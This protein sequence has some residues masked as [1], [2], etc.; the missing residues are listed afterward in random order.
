MM[1]S[2]W[3]GD[4][5]DLLLNSCSIGGGKSMVEA[6]PFFHVAAL[7]LIYSQEW[8]FEIKKEHVEGDFIWFLVCS[9]RISRPNVCPKIWESC[10]G[11]PFFSGQTLRCEVRSWC[12]SSLW[13]EMLKFLFL[14]MHVCHQS[15]NEVNRTTAQGVPQDWRHA[16]R[17][18]KDL[19][20]WTHRWLPC[21]RHSIPSSR[22]IDIGGV[23]CE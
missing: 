15:Q 2:F 23:A 17:H 8:H 6:L 5:K 9:S 1:V 3:S 18:H 14:P 12:D 21:D 19:Q 11:Y 4:T 20:H 7:Q 13:I 22:T 16:Y 10:L